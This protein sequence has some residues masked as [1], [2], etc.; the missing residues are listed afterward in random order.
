MVWA[1]FEASTEVLTQ[2]RAP[3]NGTVSELIAE[4]NDSGP[5][6]VTG[7]IDEDQAGLIGPITD[8]SMPPFALRMR[9]PGALAELAWSRWRA[10][11]VDDATSMEPVY[12]SR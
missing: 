11:D 10:G 9:H 2:A 8:V 4:L 5:V 6:L 12:L 1:H 7:E 3:R